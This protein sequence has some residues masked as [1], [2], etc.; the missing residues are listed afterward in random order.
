MLL[1]LRARLA[2]SAA[3]DERNPK[4]PRPSV[5][6]AAGGGC[7]ASPSATAGVVVQNMS[8][9]SSAPRP[10]SAAASAAA[11]IV[12]EVENTKA[13]ECGICF[14]PLKPPIFQ[15]NVGHVLCRPCREVL[16]PG[17]KCHVCRGATGGFR[18]CHAMEYIVESVR[19]P[20]PNTAYGCT[21]KPAYYDQQSHRK[22]CLHAPCHCPGEACGFVGAMEALVDHFTG[23]HGWPCSTMV[24]IDEMSNICLK[25][26]FNFV[27]LH[28]EKA[29]ATSSS[30]ANGNNSQCLFLLDV[31]RQPLS[32]AISVIFVHPHAAAVDDNQRPCLESM[33]C[34]LTYQRDLVSGSHLRADLAVH[35]EQKSKFIITCTD[36]SNGL[37]NP[38]ERFHFVVPN[39]VL[40]EE[41]DVIKV[42][43]RIQN[44]K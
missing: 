35:N 30:T 14:L 18:R 11:C 25:E 32:R 31:K 44:F 6:G 42:G 10:D 15:C 40:R 16:K 12:M 43:F 36:L 1:P 17:S 8:S 5:A 3:A 23:V 19:I 21:A 29:A 28:D 39:F 20:C 27:R 7:A 9:G 13:L 38:D 37:P 22:E 33:S 4:R 41:N 24:R 34:D 26:G 2:Q